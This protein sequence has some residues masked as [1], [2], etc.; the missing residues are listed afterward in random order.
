VNLRLA[1]SMGS[2]IAAFSEFESGEGRGFAMQNLRR[3]NLG[4]MLGRDR[5][6]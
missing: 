2:E 6:A 1:I 4:P 5:L 3:L